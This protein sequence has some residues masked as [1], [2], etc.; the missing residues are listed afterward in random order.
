MN[1]LKIFFFINNIGPYK[2]SNILFFN[3]RK[4]IVF[5]IWNWQNLI[6]YFTIVLQW[7]SSSCHQ[8]EFVSI[9]ANLRLAQNSRVKYVMNHAVKTLPHSIDKCPAIFGK[10]WRAA[11]DWTLFGSQTSKRCV[12][13]K[14]KIWKVLAFWWRAAQI[15]Y[16]NC[17]GWIIISCIS[18]SNKNFTE[19]FNNNKV[20]PIYINSLNRNR[21][22]Q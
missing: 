5:W 4:R 18:Q 2:C 20:N 7:N 9:T 19:F 12:W 11:N 8:Q 1:T 6:W 17:V 14:W 13:R 22:L 10:Y 15:N 21:V 16:F 3:L